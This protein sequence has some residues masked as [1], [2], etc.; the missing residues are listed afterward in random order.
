MT[1]SQW[2]DICRVINANWPQR[3]IANVTLAKY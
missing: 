2:A 1:E 3:P